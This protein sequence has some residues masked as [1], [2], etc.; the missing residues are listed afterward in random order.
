[1]LLEGPQ[2]LI[3]LRKAL[4]YCPSAQGHKA[5]SA[6]T[7]CFSWPWFETHVYFFATVLWVE[8]LLMLCIIDTE[9]L[10]TKK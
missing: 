2:L 3:N 7:P 4:S 5:N 1:M 10:N 8:L 9:M 6:V